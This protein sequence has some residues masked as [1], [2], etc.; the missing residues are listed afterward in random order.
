MTHRFGRAGRLYG[1]TGRVYAAITGQS[2]VG[3]KCTS[4]AD[5]PG[6]NCYCN[7]KGVCA[8]DDPLGCM[9]FTTTTTVPGKVPHRRGLR[10]RGRKRARIRSRKR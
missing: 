10:T 9:G 5:C 7:D 4:D 2:E 6:D 1:R 3:T 8:T